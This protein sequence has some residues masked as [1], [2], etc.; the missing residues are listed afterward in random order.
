MYEQQKAEKAAEEEEQWVGYAVCADR[1]YTDKSECSG[2][3]H[4]LYI[5]ETLN[6]K[7]STPTKR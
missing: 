2:E 1:V 7:Q 5:E 3:I 6:E 4:S